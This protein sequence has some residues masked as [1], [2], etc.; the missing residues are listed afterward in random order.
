VM[1]D[2]FCPQELALRLNAQLRRKARTDRLRNNVRD[3]LRA[4]VL[5]PMTGLYNR[6]YAMP[7]LSKIARQSA[8]TGR[9]FAVML[10]DLDHF[11][12]IND[13]YG[14]PVGDSVLTETAR[15]LGSQLGPADMLA[16]VGGEE[17][18]IV[19]PDTD[20]SAAFL[21][22]DRLCRRINSQPFRAPGLQE[23][24]H[25][26]ISIGV[27]IAAPR[28]SGRTFSGDRSAQTLI[29][30]ADRALYE[31]KDSGRNQVTLIRAAA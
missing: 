24:V 5:D 25:V 17:F 7:Q 14:H 28:S 8:Q 9:G 4:A 16:R 3:G 20:H 1:Q 31:A 6:R 22:A 10:A 23:P 21:A 13:T 2:G 27:V 15:R 29:G 18:M 19:V 30:Q 26:T 11:K 12:R